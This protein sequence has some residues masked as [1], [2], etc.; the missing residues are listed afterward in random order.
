MSY[1]DRLKDL[2]IPT[3][4]YIYRKLRSD[5]IHVDLYKI[6]NGIDAVGKEML[7]PINNLNQNH[8]G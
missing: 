7:F 6:L 5:L 3:L 2:G 1:T 8:I 4:E